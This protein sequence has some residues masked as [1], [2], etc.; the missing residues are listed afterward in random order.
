MGKSDVRQ[1][2]GEDP[3]TPVFAY[4]G[5]NQGVTACE[6]RRTQA[7]KESLAKF[8]EERKKEGLVLSGGRE[9]W[10]TRL[11]SAEERR[12]PTEEEGEFQLQ[13]RKF[14]PLGGGSRLRVWL[15][16]KREERNSYLGRGV[17]FVGGGSSGREKELK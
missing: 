2:E 7:E 12:P 17:P 5:F 11:V 1:R 4:K 15:F 6:R 16:Q 9:A 13:K 14:S 8:E 10:Y 3:K